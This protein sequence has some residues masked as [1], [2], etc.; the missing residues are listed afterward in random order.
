MFRLL[1]DLVVILHV[2]FVAFVV[3]GGL[4][5]VRWPRL[6]WVHFP[7]VLWGIVV[8]LAGWICPLTPFENALRVRG[9]AAAYEGDFVEHFLLPLLYPAQLT[10][11]SQFLLAAFACAV[12]VFVYW[13]VIRRTGTDPA[14]SRQIA[15]PGGK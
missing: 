14:A 8:E 13:K 12:N 7:A 3:L 11:T 6:A 15:K 9:G 2:G 1:A 5:V 4:L 10:R